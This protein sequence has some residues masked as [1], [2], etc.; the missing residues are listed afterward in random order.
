MDKKRSVG[1]ML[2]GYFDILIATL[3]GLSGLYLGLGDLTSNY[4]KF[5]GFGAIGAIALTPFTILFLIAGIFILKLK[6]A[7][8]ILNIILS[9]WFILSALPTLIFQSMGKLSSLLYSLPI[10]LV[11]SGLI[12]FLTRPNVKEQFK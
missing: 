11:F 6:K 10:V 2:C 3:F 12:Y 5:A 1:V 9:I 7:G 4:A 8:I